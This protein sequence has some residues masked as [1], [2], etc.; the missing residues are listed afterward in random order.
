MPRRKKGFLFLIILLIA[1]GLIFLLYNQDANC[2]Y[3]G[4]FCAPEGPPRETI[5]IASWNLQNFGQK[6]ANDEVVM[7]GISANLKG[8]DIIAVQE[9]SNFYEKSDPSCPKIETICPNHTNCGLIESALEK[10]L[11]ERYNLSY[12][13]VFSDEIRDE[14]YLYIYNPEKVELISAEVVSDPDETGPICDLEKNNTGKMVRQPFKAKFRAGNSTFTL[15]N[16]HTSPTKNIAELEGLEYFYK[17]EKAKGDENIIV[18]GDLNADCD[19]LSPNQQIAFRSS[20]YR[21]VISD[22][23]DTTVSK[24][25]CA[26]DRFIFGEDVKSDYTGKYGIVSG[27]TSELSDHYLVWAEFII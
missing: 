6:K 16:A 4:Y 8:Y 22:S 5:K 26:Y 13:F 21:W 19:Y 3:T 17:Q 10:S 1:A 12:Q 11:N 7:A 20:Q 9:I 25:A 24:N 18:L 14:R 23:E 27:T 2:S 15:L